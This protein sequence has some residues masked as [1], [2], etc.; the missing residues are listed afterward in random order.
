MSNGR[1]INVRSMKERAQWISDKFQELDRPLS[2]YE[3][4]EVLDFIR[5]Q[6]G[7]LKISI[8]D[9]AV[10]EV[11]GK[12]TEVLNEVAKIADLYATF[13]GRKIFDQ[14]L[15]HIHTEVSEVAL[16]LQHEEG[17]QRVLEEIVDVIGSTLSLATL[18][19][20]SVDDILQELVA[21]AY[22]LNK[23]MVE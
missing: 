19:N 9:I 18:L 7:A 4:V 8:D 23:R 20:F 21:K 14:R 17:S 22:K 1:S 6:F 10:N 13:K 15:L 16:A 12:M 11:E 3:Q 5:R 2:L